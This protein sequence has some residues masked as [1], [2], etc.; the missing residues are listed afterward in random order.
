MQTLIELALFGI[1]TAF[2]AWWFSVIVLPIFYGVPR[3]LFLAIQGKVKATSILIYIKTFLLWSFL[4]TLIAVILLNIF[5]KVA[6]FLC[7]S[8][9][10]LCGQVV[11]VCGAA[12]SAISGPGRK[13][14]NE[15]FCLTM[16]KFKKGADH[17]C[18][19]P[20]DGNNIN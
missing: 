18:I 6:L 11:G 4:F 16:S 10:F 3:S 5:P 12:L 19:N 13:S 2:G 1:A 14:L 17:L 15:D 9:G 20:A 8:T 7:N